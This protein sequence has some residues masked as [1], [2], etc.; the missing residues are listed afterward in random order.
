MI[1]DRVHLEFTEERGKTIAGKV[2]LTIKKENIVGSADA[3]WGSQNFDMNDESFFCFMKHMSAKIN[4]YYHEPWQ[5][6]INEE[7]DDHNLCEWNSE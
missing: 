1:N 3:Y 6:W 2:V 4:E 7:S 5:E